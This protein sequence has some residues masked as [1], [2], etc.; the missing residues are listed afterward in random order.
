MARKC[1]CKICGSKGDTDIFYKVTNEKGVNR[2]YCNKDEYDQLMLSQE[3]YICLMKYIAIDVLDYEDG[4][5]VPP[6]LVRKIRNLN[7]FYDYEV[8]HECFKQCNDDIKYWISTKNFDNEFG[9]SSYIMK[10]IESN[11]NDIYSK[12]KHQNK[13]KQKQDDSSIDLGLINEINDIKINNHDNGIMNFL[14]EEDL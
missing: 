6:V 2:Y 13:T 7:K 11:I 1:T 9:M 14:D 8:I 5:I 4:Q 10:I 12:W 3:K